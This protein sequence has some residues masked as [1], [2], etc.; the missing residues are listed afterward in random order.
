MKQIEVDDTK[1]PIAEGD[2]DALEKRLGVTFPGQYR[3]WLLK[4]NGGRPYPDRFRF[5]NKTG[6]YTSSVVAWFF[7]IHDG[8]YENLESNFETFKVLDRRLPENLVPIARDPGGNLVCISV[9]GA[10][11]GKVYFWDH[12][13]ESATPDYGNCHLLAN[14]FDEFIAGLQ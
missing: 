12:E 2:I 5:K 14:T 6:P 3:R 1:P 13:E 11:Q 10:D 8:E 7:A 9:A 4:H